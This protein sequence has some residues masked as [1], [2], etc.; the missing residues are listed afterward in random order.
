MQT[1][2][3]GRCSPAGPA[4]TRR[5]PPVPR[6]CGR[7]PRPPEPQRLPVGRAPTRLRGRRAQPGRGP[8]RPTRPRRSR[9]AGRGAPAGSRGR[10]WAAP[11]TPRATRERKSL[12]GTSAS[13]GEGRGE[14]RFRRPNGEIREAE[15]D[16]VASI[17]PGLH[18]SVLRDVTD[19]HH[20]D[21]QRARILDALRRLRPGAS[22]RRRP[23]TSVPRSSTTATSPRPPSTPST[24]RSAGPHWGPDSGTVAI[25]RCL[26][27]S[28]NDVSRR[29]RRGPP[30]GHGST[31]GRGPAM[32]GSG[33]R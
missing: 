11:P 2:A 13:A 32:S 20:L 16:A 14:V 29:C 6:G 27:S 30:S 4:R 26:A 10:A 28:L 22:R 8:S 9:R 18:I 24:P 33:G 19:R 31:N 12:E 25:A 17:S 3:R 23:T 21:K 5:C 1:R 15:F 7:A